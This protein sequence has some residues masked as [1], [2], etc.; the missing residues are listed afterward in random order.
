M[1]Q[2]KVTEVYKL[3]KII[4]KGSYGTVYLGNHRVS[5]DTVAIKEIKVPKNNKR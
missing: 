1:S 4:G 3:R 2:T 5:G